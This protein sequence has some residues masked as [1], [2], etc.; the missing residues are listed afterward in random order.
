MPSPERVADALR[1]ASVVADLAFDR[2]LPRDLMAVSRLYWTPLDVAVRIA[3]WIDELGIET[4]LDIGSGAGKF[5]V[6]TALASRSRLVGV[7]QR[8]R[9]VEAAQSLARLFEVE[10]R[11]RFIEG[12][13]GACPL[14][15][16][17]AYYLFDPFFENNVE[18]ELQLDQ[19]VELSPE[20]YQRD[21]ASIEAL[22]QGA[23]PGTY[24]IQYGTFGG[25]MPGE[26]R[27]IR[28]DRGFPNALTAWR[29]R[30]S[31]LE[32]VA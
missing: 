12:T 27:Q 26:Y 30:R 14:P 2:F 32:P 23:R 9:L 4:V 18:A 7:E 25:R 8:P 19:D 28:A 3:K 31:P 17:D 22:L 6:A 5:C 29:K 20:R 16:V 10:D 21:V 13:L 1:S 24:L 15:P 11:T